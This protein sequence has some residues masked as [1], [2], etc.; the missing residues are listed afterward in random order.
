MTERRHTG[1]LQVQKPLYPEGG[2]VCHTVILHPPGGMAE[3]DTVE[4]RVVQEP[5]TK[6]V[7]SNPAASKWYKSGGRFARQDVRI[8]L[9]AGAQLDW[10]PQENILFH[11]AQVDTQFR[12][13]LAEGA[14]AAGWDVVVLGRRAMGESWEKGEFRSVSEF[15]KSSGELLWAEKTNFS[16]S[17]GIRHAPQGLGWFPIFGTLWAVG[18]NC[19]SELAQELALRLPFTHRLR[20]GVTCLPGGVIIVRGLA[21]KIQELRDLFIDAWSVVRPIVHGRLAKRLRLWAT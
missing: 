9:G 7:L 2:S 18:P 3:G 20:A 5:G 12:L 11:S 6:T 19:T 1:P 21:Q 8:Q 16:A 13:E 15:G 4:V 14:S 10:L 17:S